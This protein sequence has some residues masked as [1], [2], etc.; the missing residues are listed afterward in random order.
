MTTTD[1]AAFLARKT[2]ID[3]DH[4]FDPTW[5]PGQLFGFQADLATWAIRK[6]RA[7]IF[8]DCGLGKSP[9]SLAYAENVH[10]HTGRPV[11]YVAP[12]AVTFQVEEEAAKFG[13]EAATSRD[14]R[15]AAGITVT[16][17]DRLE[18]FDPAD[19]AGLVCDESSA[20]KHFESARRGL[21]TAFARRL[22]YRLLATATA[23]PNDHTELGTS[24]EALGYLGYVDMLNRFFI[25]KRKTGAPGGSAGRRSQKAGNRWI[26]GGGGGEE[27][28]FK[29]HAEV[30]FWRWV[31]SWARALRRPSDLG[32][33]DDGFALPELIQREHLVA[34]RT[35]RPGTLFELT[36]VGLHEER[37]EERR[38]VGERCE[39]AAELLADAEPG[40]AWCNRNDEGD[41]LTMLIPGAVQVRGSDQ[42][43]SKEE[44]LRA[45]TRGEIRVLVTKPSIAGHGLN[46]Q[47]CHRMTLFPS[48]SYEQ[49]YQAVRRCWRFGQGEPVV[50]D[51][52]A[53]EGG[54]AAL[55]GMRRKAELAD[56][57]FAA[58]CQHM[59]EATDIGRADRHHTEM[60]V[61][62]WLVS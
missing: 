34:A 23:A 32:Y 25:N 59:R 44:A 61:P 7:G 30:P 57:L 46:W 21:V 18:R 2:G 17:Y 1:Y 27:W 58:L 49:Y 36:A 42:L 31:A 24:S 20:I 62:Q 40:I 45:F 35:I 51:V 10:R 16:N 55:E 48:H 13:V 15:V 39:R 3:G 54:R 50:V 11:L 37:E 47:H 8:A 26:S 41:L 28:R 6:G 43:E 5:L 38:T 14:G 60:E 9:M 33:P 29:G 12:L 56:R 52:V 22:R 53:T 4:G 19:F